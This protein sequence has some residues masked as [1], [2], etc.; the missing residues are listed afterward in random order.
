[1]DINNPPIISP[2]DHEWLTRLD[3]G[4]FVWLAKEA[5]FGK[6]EFPWEPPRPGTQVGRVG[7]KRCWK[8]GNTWGVQAGCETWWMYADGTGF[9]RKPLLLPLEGNCPKEP[10]NLPPLWVREVEKVLSSLN[11]RVDVLESQA[12]KQRYQNQIWPL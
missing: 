1:M 7:I 4:H 6:I 5:T 9:D 3:T 8:N 10:L 11:K 2:P 12:I